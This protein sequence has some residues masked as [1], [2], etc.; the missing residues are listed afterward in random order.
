MDVR[1]KM[2]HVS[3]GLADNKVISGNECILNDCLL[4][5][6]S[7]LLDLDIASH[8]L[9]LSEK[10][11]GLS[12]D[13]T[14][15]RNCSDTLKCFVVNS[16]VIRKDDTVDVFYDA[17]KDITQPLSEDFE[18]AQPLPEDFECTQPLLQDFEWESLFDL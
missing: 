6:D 12:L 10:M 2:V 9:S 15:P 17:E 13:D 4:L 18:C 3:Q 1:G 7:A 16:S 11:G 14:Y 5:L 8:D